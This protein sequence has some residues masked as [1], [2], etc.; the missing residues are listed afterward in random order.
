MNPS[1]GTCISMDSYQGS[2]YDPVSL[3]KYLYANANPVMYSDPSGYQAAKLD[4]Q[5]VCLT[6]VTII[7]SAVLMQ[8]RAALHI[9]ASLRE[10]M[11][12]AVIGLGDM[13]VTPRDW[14]DV[15]ITFPSR[16][17]DRQYIISYL[18]NRH[19]FM[20]I[21][22][23]ER[24]IHTLIPGVPAEPK[25][26]PKIFDDYTYDNG[27]YEKAEYHSGS[28]TGRKN[29]APVDGQF[30]LDNSVS[31]GDN[32][33]RRIGI[34]TNGDFVVFDETSNGVFHGHVRTWSGNGN[35]QPLTQQMKNALYKAGYVKSSTG[36]KY[37]LSDYTKT[38]MI[39]GN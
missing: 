12:D 6:V 17:Y 39:G 35:N 33:N 38:K 14:K 19:L 7:A 20:P 22:A 15:F 9:F 3:H 25:D 2:I 32:T 8:D 27:V 21:Y 10:N 29:P 36:T 23:I 16:N 28:T 18:M 5:L 1:T 34:D 26:E 30:A 13:Y 11:R 4:E 24:E 31:I 37:K